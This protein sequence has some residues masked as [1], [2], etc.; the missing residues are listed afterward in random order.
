MG[1]NELR[2][3]DVVVLVPGRCFK[4]VGRDLRIREIAVIMNVV[5]IVCAFSVHRSSRQSSVYKCRKVSRSRLGNVKIE[6][7]S[8]GSEAKFIGNVNP[9]EWTI[10][11]I[12]AHRNKWRQSLHDERFAN[13]PDNTAP[14]EII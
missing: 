3:W 9:V 2:D 4:K 1:E 7:T 8:P 12:D 5:E 13:C 10:F 6:Q 11:I 14:Y